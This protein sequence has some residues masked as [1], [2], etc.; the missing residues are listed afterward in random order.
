MPPL[1]EI[2]KVE[3]EVLADHSEETTGFLTLKRVTLAVRGRGAPFRYD[4]V[5]RAALDA[6]VIAAHHPGA[7]GE[8]CVFLRSAV[9]P[10]VALRRAA[11]V[12]GGVL[13]ELPG[14]LI[15]PG[16]APAA[17]AARELEEELGFAA[18]PAAMQPLG[19]WSLPAPG[20]VGEMHH[21]FHVPVDPAARRPPAGDGSP[22][23]EGASILSVPLREALAACRSGA[24]RDAKT[25][26]ALR[27]LVEILG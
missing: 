14:G 6:A 2:P 4:L 21:F 25:E 8:P 1:P 26:L 11:P 27:R 3:L 13:W 5:E 10:P 18:S 22:L 15:D 17:A 19:G 12:P 23:E 24:I 7:D 9:R 16:E 20:F